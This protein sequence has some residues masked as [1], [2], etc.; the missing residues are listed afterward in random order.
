MDKGI[1]EIRLF[2]NV[3]KEQ[4]ELPKNSEELREHIKEAIVAVK[5]G[6]D[7]AEIEDNS[8]N[9]FI[10]A[11]ILWLESLLALADIELNTNLT[12]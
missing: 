4:G 7:Q 12:L 6:M 1:D 2:L 11:N 8:V 9:T 10:D 3:L 5:Q